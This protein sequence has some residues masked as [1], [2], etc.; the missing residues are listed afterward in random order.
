MLSYF[1]GF[2]GFFKRFLDFDTMINKGLPNFTSRSCCFNVKNS[3]FF[4]VKGDSN[5]LSNKWTF[6]EWVPIMEG[7]V[8]RVFQGFYLDLC[9]KSFLYKLLLK[10][11]CSFIFFFASVGTLYNWPLRNRNN[12]WGYFV[13]IPGRIPSLRS[14]P[15]K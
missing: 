15:P 14:Y 6:L 4:K 3:E 7:R 5:T 12:R 8:F 9:I 11:I 1:T 2:Y 10:Q 13:L